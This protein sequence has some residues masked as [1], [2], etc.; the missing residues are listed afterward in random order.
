MNLPSLSV[1]P[2]TA[3]CRCHASQA[4][5]RMRTRKRTL[6]PNPEHLATGPPPLTPP[7][8]QTPLIPSGAVHANEITSAPS[9]KSTSPWSVRQL[10]LPEHP[11]PPLRYKA[12]L[13]KQPTKVTIPKTKPTATADPPRPNPT[14]HLLSSPPTQTPPP[15]QVTRMTGRVTRPMT[16]WVTLPTATRTRATVTQTQKEAVAE[17]AT[18]ASPSPQT[19]PLSGGGK[20]PIAHLTRRRLVG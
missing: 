4:T 5:R 10:S 9:P 1:G 20:A 17:E 13:L 7:S 15:T 8:S 18:P 2:L 11:V 19:L 6:L 3:G 16:T 12:G 14:I